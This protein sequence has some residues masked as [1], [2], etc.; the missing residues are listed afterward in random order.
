MLKKREPKM[1]IED[2]KPERVENPYADQPEGLDPY[3]K[4]TK[5]YVNGVFGDETSNLYKRVFPM[6][7]V[8]GQVGTSIPVPGSEDVDADPDDGL[9]GESFASMMKQQIIDDLR[10]GI[11][12]DEDY[13]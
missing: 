6:G 13:R 1:S 10:A 4:A 2:D 11:Y 8:E 12:A 5:D 3:V 9:T 7:S